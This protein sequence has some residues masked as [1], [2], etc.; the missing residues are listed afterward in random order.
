MFHADLIGVEAV[1][2]QIRA[3]A[4]EDP[5]FWKPSP[6]LERLAENGRRFVD[7]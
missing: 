4:E 7:L 6:L 3:F 5:V 1:L 2:A